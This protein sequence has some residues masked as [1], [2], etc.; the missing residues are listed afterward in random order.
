MQRSLHCSMHNHSFG[1]DLGIV[2]MCT[3]IYMYSG[4]L[5]WVATSWLSRLPS[6]QLGQWRCIHVFCFNECT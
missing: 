1:K 4:R 3:C 6:Q 5:Y 2:V